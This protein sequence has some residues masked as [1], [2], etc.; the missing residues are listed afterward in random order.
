MDVLEI[1]VVAY[2]GLGFSSGGHRAQ[3]RKIAAWLY[4]GGSFTSPQIFDDGAH[5]KYLARLSGSTILDQIIAMEPGR[6]LALFTARTQLQSEKTTRQQISGIWDLG[7][8]ISLNLT[9]PM[10]PL[11][12]PAH[13]NEPNW[14]ASFIKAGGCTHGSIRLTGVKGPIPARRRLP[15]ESSPWKEERGHTG[16]SPSTHKGMHTGK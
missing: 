3:V 8:R 4:N 16:G 10:E 1:P 14:G 9:S 15:T 5:K 6:D 7:K 13:K 11:R 12:D 2:F